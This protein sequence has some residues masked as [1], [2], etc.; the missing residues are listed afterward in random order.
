MRPHLRAGWS[1]ASN[2]AAAFGGSLVTTL[3]AVRFPIE[4]GFARS[5]DLE[6]IQGL[7]AQKPLVQAAISRPDHPVFSADGLLSDRWGSPLVV[8]PEAWKQLELRSAGPDKLP[9]TEDDLVLTPAGIQPRSE[10]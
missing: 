4:F 7:N 8:H 3:G 2:S 6:S 10:K 1:S 9:F 5:V